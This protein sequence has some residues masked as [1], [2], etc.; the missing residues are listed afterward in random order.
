MRVILDAGALI[1]IDRGDREVASLL[2]LARRAGSDLV[3]SAPVVGQ[4]WRDGSRQVAL[5]RALRMVDVQEVNQSDAQKAGE[6]LRHTGGSDIVDALVA[7]L[8]RS[9]DQIF[10]SDQHD[11]DE[12]LVARNVKAFA[13]AI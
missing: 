1:A 2:E 7:L 6:L 13:V 5:V 12:L 4:V 11:I 3:T 9:G 8:V 10:T